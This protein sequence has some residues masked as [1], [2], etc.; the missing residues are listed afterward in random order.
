MKKK[1]AI[2]QS[3][4]IPWKGYFD[5]I[6]M[7]DEFILYD[8][9]Q[10]TKRD[11]RNR[12][13]I[14]TPNG[15]L[16]LTIPVKVKGKFS[17][18]INETEVEDCDWAEKHWKTIVM[19]YS[20]TPY[21]QDYSKLF[22]SLYQQASDMKYLSDINY[23]F[24]KTICDILEIKTRLTWSSSFKLAEG[25]TERLLDICIQT[26]GNQYFSGPAAKDYIQ[27][28]I[29][30]DAGVGLN[31]IDYS[32]YS[33]Y[34]QKFGEFCHGVTVLDLLFNTGSESR[35]YMKTFPKEGSLAR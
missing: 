1:V 24:I 15:L 23:L 19:N 14:K 31:W 27:E 28:N 35:N 34:P 29:F 3:N 17:Q 4:Y 9:M 18:K 13:Q 32:G 6:N 5:M 8:D 22:E 33:V 20:K 11:W 26:K 30:K 16:W 2:S 21:F 25:K 10:Y 7:V 12:N